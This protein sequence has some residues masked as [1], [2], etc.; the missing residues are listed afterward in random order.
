[1]PTHPLDDL[2]DDIKAR[3]VPYATLAAVGVAAAMLLAAR[4]VPDDRSSVRKAVDRATEAAG[5]RLAQTRDRLSA[6]EDVGSVVETSGIGRTTVMM[7]IGS[8]LTGSLAGWLKSRDE[9][10]ARPQDTTP[11]EAGGPDQDERLSELTVPELR[12]IATERDLTGRSSMNKGELVDAL[13]AD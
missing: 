12:S 6:D 4:T 13:A 5:D 11:A 1:M 8:V 2:I 10:R 3:P 9:Q 7:V